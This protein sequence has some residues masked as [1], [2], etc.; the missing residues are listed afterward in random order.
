MKLS[1]IYNRNKDED[2]LLDQCKKG[3]PK[4]QKILYEK[5]Y[6]QMY[7]LCLRY[8]KNNEDAVDVV[9]E[10]FLK[11]FNKLKSFNFESKFTTWMQSIFIYTAIDYFRSNKKYKEQFVLTNDVK[12][13]QDQYVFEESNIDTTSN[14]LSQQQLFDL[15]KNLPPATRIVFNLYVIDEMPHKE[16]AKQ[17]KIS[18]GTSKWHLSNARK[19]LAAEINKQIGNYKKEEN[20]AQ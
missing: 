2:Y 11:V 17:L 9:H 10:G 1:V 15:V 7:T 6:N 5:H 14:Q 12:F 8:V 19:L 3:N 18:E 16:I 20:G 13:V 4:A